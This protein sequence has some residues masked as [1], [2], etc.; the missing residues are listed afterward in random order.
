MPVIRKNLV[1]ILASLLIVFILV[2]CSENR[3]LH[4]ATEVAEQYLVELKEKVSDSTI[5]LTEAE[6]EQFGKMFAFAAY[7]EKCGEDFRI[8]VNS[9]CTVTDS[10]F[11]AELSGRS[12][13]AFAELTV[14]LFSDDSVKYDFSLNKN[15]ASSSLSAKTFPS[16]KEAHTAVGDAIGLVRVNLSGN[17]PEDEL[18][19][20]L[21][22]MQDAG[23]YGD[24]S[25]TNDVRVFHISSAGITNT[26]TPQLS[27]VLFAVRLFRKKKWLKNT[28]IFLRQY[29]K[30]VIFPG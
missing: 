13:D 18:E 28:L 25:V 30:A 14:G 19:S 29:S 3:R 26:I 1:I 10:Y 4:E 15:I 2:G 24:V 23:F 22:S 20:L 7:S 27:V 11:A 8:N 5:Y 9:D 6:P 21:T 17:V 12:A 16:V